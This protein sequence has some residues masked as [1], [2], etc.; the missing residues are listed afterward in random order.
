MRYLDS[1]AERERRDFRILRSDLSETVSESEGASVYDAIVDQIDWDQS[2]P[3]LTFLR[4]LNDSQRVLVSVWQ[5]HEHAMF[6]GIEAA[7]G[8][9]GRDIVEMAADGAERLGSPRMRSMLMRALGENPDWDALESEWFEHADGADA[10]SFIK[11]RD[12]TPATHIVRVVCR[13]R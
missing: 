4:R 3:W 6:N 11:A 7:I 10:V 13:I 8:F 5:V 1:A 9:H 12:K 2:F